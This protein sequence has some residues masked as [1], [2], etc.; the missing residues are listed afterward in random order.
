MKATTRLIELSAMHPRLLWDDIVASAAVVLGRAAKT[1][2]RFQL[3]LRDVPGF[4]SERVTLAIHAGSVAAVD[5]ARVQ[6]T[7]EPARL[8]ELA[9]IAM[10]GLSLY[11]GGGHEI[12][13]VAVR[14]SAADY[15]VDESR[16]RLEIAGRSRRSD[17]ES[18][19]QE[20]WQRLASRTTGGFFVFVA[21]FETPVGRLGFGR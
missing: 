20:K 9:A 2:V 13:D 8:V 5:L 21:E 17:F 18:A 3:E 15:L 4:G 19:W 10:A 7:Y 6:R 11:H 1:L 12:M 16:H 14:G